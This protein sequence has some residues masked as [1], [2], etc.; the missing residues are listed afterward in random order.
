MIVLCVIVWKVFSV[1]FACVG[2][3]C[4]AL[5]CKPSALIVSLTCMLEAM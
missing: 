2:Q 3:Y 5:K 4:I 1:H